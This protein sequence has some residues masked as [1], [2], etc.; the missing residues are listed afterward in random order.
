MFAGKVA[1]VT[2]G[3]QG[4]GRAIAREFAQKRRARRRDRRCREN[5]YFVGDVG[6]EGA[7]ERFAA[8]VVADFGRV[9]FLIHNAPPPMKG[10]DSC[11]YEEFLC[12]FAGGR[13]RAFYLTK[14]FFAAFRAGRGHCE[15]LF[16]ARVHEP[17]A[18]GELFGGQGRDRRAHARA[19]RQPCGPVCA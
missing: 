7:L 4:I 12:S 17:A 16:H 14:L 8:K 10:I 1:V 13:G 15:H 5:P 9:D 19:G 3:A 2:G 18:D 11:S 6:D